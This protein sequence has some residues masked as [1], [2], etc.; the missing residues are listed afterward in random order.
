[1]TSGRPAD[2]DGA[3]FRRIVVVVAVVLTASLAGCS[4]GAGPPSEGATATTTDPSDEVPRTTSGTSSTTVKTADGT[5]TIGGGDV[6]ATPVVV[7]PSNA[8][9]VS[10]NESAVAEGEVLRRLLD[11]A[12]AE[13]GTV[14]SLERESVLDVRD[15]LDD[16]PHFDGDDGEFGYYVRYRGTVLRVRLLLHE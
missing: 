2:R 5:P 7:A 6:Y 13:N 10:F 9:T 12:I 4:F 3:G 16:L 8:T 15:A 14:E 11:D 1:M